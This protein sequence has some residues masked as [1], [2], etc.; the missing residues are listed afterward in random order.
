[1][2]E[3]SIESGKMI[4]ISI[5]LPADVVKYMDEDPYIGDRGKFIAWL[6]KRFQKELEKSRREAEANKDNPYTLSDIL[7]KGDA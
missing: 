1:M 2:N 5:T 6:I 7:K 3:Q 4:E